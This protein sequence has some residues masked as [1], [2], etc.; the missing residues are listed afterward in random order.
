MDSLHNCL[1]KQ[2]KLAM[3][4]EK[5]MMEV[6]SMPKVMAYNASAEASISSLRAKMTN[7]EAKK[8]QLIEDMISGLL[9]ASE[10]D[11]MN[12]RLDKQLSQLQHDYC[13]ALNEKNELEQLGTSTEGWIRSLKEYGAFRVIDR[14]LM[15]ILVDKIFVYDNTHLQI[16]L[17]FA[18]P[19]KD[20]YRYMDRIEEAMK[21]AV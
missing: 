15:E 16:K 8:E 7:V 19:F 21:D 12:K 9:D 3:D 5:F 13:E 20:V 18:D 6:R 1:N 11:F 10:Y 17:N 2:L 4:Y 14:S